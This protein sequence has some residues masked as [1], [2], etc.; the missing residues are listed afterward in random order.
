MCPEKPV[1]PFCEIQCCCRIPELVVRI[2]AHGDYWALVPSCKIATPFL[3]RGHPRVINDD[4]AKVTVTGS[5]PG[6]S[7]NTRIL[8]LLAN[9][10]IAPDKVIYRAR[11]S[12]LLATSHLPGDDVLK[13]NPTDRGQGPA[14]HKLR[15]LCWRH[16][17]Y[18]GFPTDCECHL[19]REL[20]C[21]FAP[22]N[23][24]FAWT[25]TPTK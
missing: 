11:D 25:Y 18:R 24:Q 15:R 5:C 14:L 22:H 8:V 17:S 3:I 19:K 13:R 16:I 23:V 7:L 1:S 6:Q 2:V 21:E 4:A 12:C 9:Q 20:S 10:D